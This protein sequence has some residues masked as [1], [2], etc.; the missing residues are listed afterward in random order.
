MEK[1]MSIVPVVAWVSLTLSLVQTFLLLREAS[2]PELDHLLGFS[3]L[4]PGIGR[5]V[6]L[7][8]AALKLWAALVLG[9][10]LLNTLRPGWLGDH[11]NTLRVSIRLFFG[12]YLVVQ[13]I[14]VNI[15]LYLWRKQE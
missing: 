8:L 15:A 5:I 7:A 9:F 12:V 2:G 14:A 13:P 10:F 4:P 1:V 6:F 3:V 11:N